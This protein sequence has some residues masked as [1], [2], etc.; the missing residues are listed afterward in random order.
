MY[1][2]NGNGAMKNMY[3][4]ISSCSVIHITFKDNLKTINHDK[5][6]RRGET[7]IRRPKTRC[8]LPCSLSISSLCLCQ[9]RCQNRIHCRNDLASTMHK[10]KTHKKAALHNCLPC[11]FLLLKEIPFCFKD[12]VAFLIEINR[13]IFA[14]LFFRDKYEDL[15]NSLR[16]LWFNDHLGLVN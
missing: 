13:T 1:E 5:N 12:M 15:P 7:R 8:G 10:I 4:H 9:L 14:R 6:K 16:F 3:W 2:A 11:I